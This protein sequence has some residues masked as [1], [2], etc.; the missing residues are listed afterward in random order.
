LAAGLPHRRELRGVR[1][2]HIELGALI[3]AVSV[4]LEGCI[5]LC[6]Q[7]AVHRDLLGPLHAERP[8]V[9]R[10]HV[11]IVQVLIVLLVPGENLAPRL[12][13]AGGVGARGW[14]FNRVLV[15]L[16]VVLGVEELV[17]GLRLGLSDQHLGHNVLFGE[18]GVVCLLFRE[19]ALFVLLLLVEVDLGAQGLLQLLVVFLRGH[20]F[21][22]S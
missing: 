18:E 7:R 22:A 1:H 19:Q 15:P 14:A 5:Q 4:F 6:P 17:E 20:L 16:V 13:V 2:S 21:F 11:L 10:A 12:I 9:R 8:V 3:T